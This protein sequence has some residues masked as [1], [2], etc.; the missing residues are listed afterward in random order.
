MTTDVA[1]HPAAGDT[2]AALAFL[3]KLRASYDMSETI[4]FES[5]ARGDNQPD[6]DLDLA[7]VLNGQRGDFID[8]KIDIYGRPGVRCFD[9]DRSSRTGF[10]DVER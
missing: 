1:I 3:E 2:R 6:S 4:T 10:P 8:T 9:G 5:R 7:V